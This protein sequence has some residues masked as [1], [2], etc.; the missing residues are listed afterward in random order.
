VGVVREWKKV[1]SRELGITTSA[2]S[3]HARTVLKELKINGNVWSSILQFKLEAFLHFSCSILVFLY[4]FVATK[5]C[6]WEI[7]CGC[8]F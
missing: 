7:V 5:E 4:D 6:D 3:G 1:S 2:I 8:W